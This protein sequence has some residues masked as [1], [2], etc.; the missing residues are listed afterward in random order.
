MN[1]I[2]GVGNCNIHVFS[3]ACIVFF[4]SSIIRC[5]FWLDH[6]KNVPQFFVLV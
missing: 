5:S 6:T 1:P 3:L 2:K 4:K